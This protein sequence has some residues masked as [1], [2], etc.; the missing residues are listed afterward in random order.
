MSWNWV[1]DRITQSINHNIYIYMHSA[2]VQTNSHVHMCMGYSI[3]YWNPASLV[4]LSAAELVMS[5]A[6]TDPLDGGIIHKLSKGTLKSLQNS[7]FIKLMF[8]LMSQQPI[9]AVPTNSLLRNLSARLV[10]FTC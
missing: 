9:L 5:I 7:E 4:A 6:T 1:L 10:S 2:S 3:L 8:S